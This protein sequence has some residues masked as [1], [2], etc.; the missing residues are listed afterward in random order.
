[1]DIFN[2]ARTGGVGFISS[3]LKSGRD[4]NVKD[5]NGMTALILAV[6]CGQKDALK[7][8]LRGNVDLNAQDKW[9]Q[10]ASRTF[11]PSSGSMRSTGSP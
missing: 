11:S 4:A 3:Y 6:D 5:S 9:G 7:L 2:A 1:M 8:L 10:T